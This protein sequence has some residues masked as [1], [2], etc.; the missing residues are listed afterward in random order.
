MQRMISTATPLPLC[1]AGHV[2]RYMHDLRGLR[3]GGGHYIE[4]ACSQ[5]NRHAS[6]DDALAQWCASGGHAISSACDQRE[7][8]LGNVVSINRIK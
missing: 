8:P 4:C 3:A 7:L 2:A 1:R 6:F 5:T